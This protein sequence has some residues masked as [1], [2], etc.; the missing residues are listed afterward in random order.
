MNRNF[1]DFQKGH[2]YVYTGTKR[3][4][5]WNSDGR[6][7]FVLDHKA[8]QCKG[9]IGFNC[10]SFNNKDDWAW[11]AGSGNWIEVED[12]SNKDLRVNAGEHYYVSQKNLIT[13]ARHNDLIL[14]N[15]YYKL[16]RPPFSEVKED[17]KKEQPFV[18]KKIKL[19]DNDEE[20]IESVKPEEF[21]CLCHVWKDSQVEGKTLFDIAGQGVMTPMKTTQLVYK[22]SNFNDAYFIIPAKR[23]EE[24]LKFV[25][26]VN[27]SDL[28]PGIKV[29]IK[30][31]AEWMDKDPRAMRGKFLTVKGKDSHGWGAWNENTVIYNRKDGI[32]F[33]ECPYRY[34]LHWIEKIVEEDET[35]SVHDGISN[36]TLSFNSHSL[37][38]ERAHASKVGNF[39]SVSENKKHKQSKYIK[40]NKK[41]IKKNKEYKVHKQEYISLSKK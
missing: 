25:S 23:V 24:A 30:E 37:D 18:I 10:A 6:M 7:D 35:I 31:N 36:F 4:R 26:N 41:P 40:L 32:F 16:V 13:R 12:P 28:K 22:D 15:G 9:T 17:V 33:E 5:G 34:P 29:K 2:W 14:Y 3:E 21:P 39:I 11:N 1:E 38:P 27:L 20:M 8:V 19:S